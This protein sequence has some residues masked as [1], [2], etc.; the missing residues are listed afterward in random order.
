MLRAN[1]TTFSRRETLTIDSFDP[2]LLQPLGFSESVE[3]VFGAF[4]PFT[5]TLA[6]DH[7]AYHRLF[8]GDL[9]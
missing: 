3:R 5:A 2:L 6:R 4:A 9:S 1:N 8:H 7:N